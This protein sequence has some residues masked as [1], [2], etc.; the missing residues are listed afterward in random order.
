ME[1]TSCCIHPNE[2]FQKTAQSKGQKH[3]EIFDQTYNKLI[4]QQNPKLTRKILYGDFDRRNQDRAS[5]VRQTGKIIEVFRI[6]VLF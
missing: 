4:P 3:A 6:L 1:H 2:K 5:W